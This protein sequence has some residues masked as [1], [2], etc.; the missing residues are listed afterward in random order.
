MNLDFEPLLWVLT[1]KLKYETLLGNKY[2]TGTKIDLYIKIY[3]DIYNFIYNFQTMDTFSIFRTIQVLQKNIYLAPNKINS[4]IVKNIE[5]H[6]RY[7]F[8]GKCHKEGYIEKKSIKNIQYEE[9]YTE[10]DNFKGYIRIPILFDATIIHPQ[11]NQIISSKITSKNDFGLRS[12]LEPLDI[13]IPYD[14]NIPMYK[15]G[16][17]IDI[18]IIDI[19]CNMGNTSIQ[20]FAKIASEK[21]NK[22]YNKTTRDILNISSSTQKEKDNIASDI[23]SGQHLWPCLNRHYSS[24]TIP[25]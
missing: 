21:D 18:R 8:E 5:D 19:R 2:I 25:K 17:I 1:L 11:I 23:G 14:D 22:K 16:D 4:D 13:M 24:L 15:I 6:V 9:M 3:T 20:I 7:I 10:V 12:T